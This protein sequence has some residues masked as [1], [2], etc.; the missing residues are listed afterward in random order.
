MISGLPQST[1]A[2]VRKLELQGSQRNKLK[3]N[4]TPLAAGDISFILKEKLQSGEFA[5]HFKDCELHTTVQREPF[6]KNWL[7]IAGRTEAFLEMKIKALEATASVKCSW[8]PDFK[9]SIQNSSMKGILGSVGGDS[10]IAW[11]TDVLHQ[12]LR[13]S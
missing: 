11:E 2:N 7:A 13:S 6:E 10:K 4:I 8:R 9:F 1:Q 5:E 3:I 12:A